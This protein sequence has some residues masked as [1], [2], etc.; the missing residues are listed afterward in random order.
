[1]KKYSGYD[2]TKPFNSSIAYLER[3]E[4]RWEDCDEAKLQGNL[5]QYFRGLHVIFM[6]TQPF[7]KETEER[8]KC[9]ELIKKC[10]DEIENSK[11]INPNAQE[12]V[13]TDLEL[14]LD[15]FREYLVNLLFKYKVTYVQ[16]DK[17]NIAEEIKSDYN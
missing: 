4:K 7:F 15:E 17:K 2:E 5:M 14:L 1:M 9:R 8:I 6:N 3:L 10:E 13:L 12:I 16:I 11:K